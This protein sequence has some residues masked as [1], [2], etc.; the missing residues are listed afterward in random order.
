MSSTCPGSGNLAD[1]LLL[2]ARLRS[3]PQ[4]LI[5]PIFI[6]LHVAGSPSCAF[7][8][9]LISTIVSMLSYA[10]RLWRNCGV[11]VFCR[12]CFTGWYCRCSSQ[13]TSSTTTNT[14]HAPA[15]KLWLGKPLQ[16]IAAAP[17]WGSVVSHVYPAG[18]LQSSGRARSKVL[19]I[20][21]GPTVPHACLNML[22]PAPSVAYQLVSIRQQCMKLCCR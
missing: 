17:C 8:P 9:F 1:R 20:D 14:L 2:P 15:F 11:C 12:H 19:F 21:R 22:A 4:S 18:G 13:L 10:C 6:R 16:E 5:S 7:L 3:W